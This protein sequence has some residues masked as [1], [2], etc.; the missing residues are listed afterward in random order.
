MVHDQAPRYQHVQPGPAAYDSV[1]REALDYLNGAVLQ[2]SSSPNLLSTQRTARELQKTAEYLAQLRLE[3]ELFGQ[4]SPKWR[5]KFAEREIVTQR[6]AL[7]RIKDK[8]TDPGGQFLARYRTNMDHGNAHCNTEQ[9]ATAELARPHGQD[10]GIGWTDT[11]IRAAHEWAERELVGLNTELE[12]LAEA[13]K[14][15]IRQYSDEMD[16]TNRYGGY[17]RNMGYMK[18]R[19]PEDLKALENT[20]DTS[21]RPPMAPRW[22]LGSEWIR[23][24]AVGT[25]N[26]MAPG[27]DADC[28]VDRAQFMERYK[29]P[30]DK[31]K[32]AGI[33]ASFP[34]RS[35]YQD[36]YL[37]PTFVETGMV[38]VLPPAT[39]RTTFE[40]PV[41]VRG[42]GS[43][44]GI[45]PVQVQLK[46]YGVNPTP[47]YLAAFDG[48]VP[49]SREV[50][51]FPVSETKDSYRWPEK[52]KPKDVFLS[53]E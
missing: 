28:H 16:I 37:N 11:S 2:L 38:S 9:C 1:Y 25:Q 8:L 7:L 51:P 49:M 24:E 13:A 14:K 26:Y 18:K 12:P 23:A 48:A 15:R 5:E 27:D 17:R 50:E 10:D 22:H 4:A 46:G 40:Q 35:E 52:P 34:G 29:V 44:V 43:M 42:R 20:L 21:I 30:Q 3:D 41:G 47:N 32:A 53:M 39:H 45:D 33:E 6:Q 31:I 36:E 19:N